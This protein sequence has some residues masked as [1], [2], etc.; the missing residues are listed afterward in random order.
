MEGKDFGQINENNKLN[1]GSINE[2]GCA[3]GAET[4]ANANQDGGKKKRKPGRPRN[5]PKVH[6]GGAVEN[7][8]QDQSGGAVEN[9]IE[10][11]GGRKKKS[12]K[13]SKKGSRKGSKKSKDIV[14]YEG[15]SGD[16]DMKPFK[17]N[18]E[19]TTHV[20]QLLGGD[21]ESLNKSLRH[22][23]VK[24]II[25]TYINEYKDKYKGKSLYERIKKELTQIKNNLYKKIND[26]INEMLKNPKPRKQR[27]T[28][29]ITNGKKKSKGFSSESDSE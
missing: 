13:G 28:K 15:G 2:C 12:K 14:L 11:Q 6:S 3:S 8:N 29:K 5:M 17:I 10:L 9:S 18:A 7:A 20:I 22:K 27:K 1:G 16:E 21:Y 24:S 23:A 26:K 25:W 4:T 19:L